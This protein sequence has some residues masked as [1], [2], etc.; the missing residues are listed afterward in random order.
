MA[1]QEANITVCRWPLC[2]FRRDDL[3]TIHRRDCGDSAKFFM[4]TA[5][6]VIEVVECQ[7]RRLM[8]RDLHKDDCCWFRWVWKYV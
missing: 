7:L 2:Q 1:P 4:P 6:L 3:S 5:S 8:S